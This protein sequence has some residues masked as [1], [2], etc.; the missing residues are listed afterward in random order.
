M[1]ADV[2]ELEARVQMLASKQLG[3]NLAPGDVFI[4]EEGGGA[5]LGDPLERDPE[6]VAQDVRDGYVTSEAAGAAYGVVVDRRGQ[7]DTA[8]T[9]QERDRIRAERRGWDRAS[10]V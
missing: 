2:D 8:E 3:L 6:R 4:Q 1:P 5:G 7:L 9:E 10:D